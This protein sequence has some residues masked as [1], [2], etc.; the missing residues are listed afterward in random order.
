MNNLQTQTEE[1]SCTGKSPKS[2]GLWSRIAVFLGRDIKS[3]LPRYKKMGAENDILKIPRVPPMEPLVD[4]NKLPRMAFRREVLDWRDNFHATAIITITKLRDDF[5]VQTCIELDKTSL[6]RKLITRSADEVLQ[7]SFIRM[8]RWPLITTLRLEEAKLNACAQRLASFDKVNL[9]FDIRIMNA[10]CIS[11][12]DVSFRPSNKSFILSQTQILLLGP[13]GL[14]EHFCKQ[15]NHLSKILLDI[16][17][18]S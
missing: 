18:S 11:L 17:E 7:D 14:A 3:F 6:F 15:A 1:S 2:G 13:E 4:F 12:H 5:V 9:T 8:V 16:E 10:E